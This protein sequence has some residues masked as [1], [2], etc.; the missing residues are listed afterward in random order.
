MIVYFEILNIIHL[1][2]INEMS[3]GAFEEIGG[4]I[5]RENVRVK[6]SEW[7]CFDHRTWPLVASQCS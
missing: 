3:V 7:L 6:P 5:V 1:T 2:L 4:K